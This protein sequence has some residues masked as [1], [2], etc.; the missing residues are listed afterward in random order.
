MFL[1]Y[2]FV[3]SVLRALWLATQAPHIHC[4]SLIQLQLLRASDAKLAEVIPEIA[5]EG[6]EIE[7]VCL[8]WIY[9]WNRKKIFLFTRAN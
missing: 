2:T 6:V 7:I 8:T 9:R 4:Y 5:E 1:V 3:D